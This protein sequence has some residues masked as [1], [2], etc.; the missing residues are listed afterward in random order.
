M[1]KHDEQVT[2]NFNLK[3]LEKECVIPD[4]LLDN[5]RKLLFNL[6]VIR[7]E[8]S[9]PIVIIS[10]Y[11]NEAFNEKCG[12]ADNSQHLQATAADL[13]VKG[14]TASELHAIIEKLIRERKILQGGLGLY[15]RGENYFIHYDIRGLKAR[16]RG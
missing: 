1:K 14:L 9:K 5:A 3:E 15:D 2:I 8:I 10:G 6:Q 4:H 16:W 13:R 11:R 12:G 7:N